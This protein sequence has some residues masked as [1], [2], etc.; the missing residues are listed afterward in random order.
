MKIQNNKSIRHSMQNSI[1]NHYTFT[2]NSTQTIQSIHN[3]LHYKFNTQF[4]ANS[5]Q[6]QYKFNTHSMHHQYI[7]Q[8][9]QYIIQYE[10]QY[11]F[12]ANS[13][14]TQYT[15]QSTQINKRSTHIPN[16]LPSTIQY[17][18]QYIIQCKFNTH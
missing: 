10:S 9:N 17:N 16:T 14:H 5:I 15:I 4:N 1:R 13:I 18:I 3:S 7:V 6:V 2:A 8:A 12:N 11:T